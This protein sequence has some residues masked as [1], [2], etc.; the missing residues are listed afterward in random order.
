M[1]KSVRKQVKGQVWD[2]VMVQV[3]GQVMDQVG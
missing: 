2:Q 1:L 3:G